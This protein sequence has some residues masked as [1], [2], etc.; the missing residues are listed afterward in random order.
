[1]AF[2]VSCTQG[3]RAHDFN[4]QD[5]TAVGRFHVGSPSQGLTVPV[6]QI[7]CKAPRPVDQSIPPP[8]ASG[9]KM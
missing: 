7:Y 8:T 5:S 2:K 3:I 6:H 1:M 9:P 4:G